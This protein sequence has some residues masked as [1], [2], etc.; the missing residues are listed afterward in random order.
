VE[1]AGGLQSSDI[2]SRLTARS[3]SHS[4]HDRRPELPSLTAQEQI[5]T[6]LPTA[7]GLLVSLQT[8]FDGFLGVPR[9]SSSSVPRS[10]SAVD[11]EEPRNPRTRHR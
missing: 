9:S 2:E 5:R 11:P 8:S 1:R 6:S 4:A 3:R 7:K 10:S